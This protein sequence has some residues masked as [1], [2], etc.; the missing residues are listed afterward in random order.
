[1][2]DALAALKCRVL[3]HLPAR[4]QRRHP[5]APLVAL[6]NADCSP[7][8][9]RRDAAVYDGVVCQR[10]ATPDRLQRFAL[11]AD[12]AAVVADLHHQYGKALYD[13]FQMPPGS[14]ER[15]A[16][17]N[18]CS[19]RAH[20]V[21]AALTRPMRA[22]RT[23]D[24]PDLAPA[25]RQADLLRQLLGNAKGLVLGEVHAQQGSKRLLI[26]HMAL[27]RHLGVDTLYMEHLQ[28]DLHQADLD[29]LHRHGIHTGALKRF[30]AEQDHGHHMQVESGNTF[31]NVVDAAFNAGI[32]VVALDLMSSYH[33]HGVK[34]PAGHPEETG[35]DLRT[36]LFNHVAALRIRQDQLDQVGKPGPQRWVALVGNAH[37]G[38]FNGI[39]G[40]AERLEVASLRMEDTN[41]SWSDA[42]KVGHDPGRTVEPDAWRAGGE[43]QCDY[44]LKVPVT[45]GRDQ[46]ET[47]APCT[48]SEA[49]QRR[50]DRWAAA[51]PTPP[52]SRA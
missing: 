15:V 49:R 19:K 47:P 51:A 7:G 36:K 14:P 8:T 40:I 38:T 22:S 13:D 6:R 2:L 35:L 1:M 16:L 24:C 26:D 48:A 44:L 23:R 39:A 43:L 18:F 37:A 12:R 34:V 41:P 42:L 10:P 11:P 17:D 27:L 52:Q 21:D 32:R 9:R 5:V 46:R 31:S 25:R 33:L 30:L 4:V 50:Q 20:L 45:P 3:S 28:A 29:Q